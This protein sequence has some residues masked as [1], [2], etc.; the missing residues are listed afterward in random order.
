MDFLTTVSHTIT[1][2]GLLTPGE[3]CL[4]ALSGGADSVALLTA[5]IRLGFE[6]VAAHCNF[7]LRGAES[8][9]DEAFSRR[10]CAKL[11]VRLHVRRFDTAAE[12]RA[13]GESI[14]MAARRLRYAWFAELMA[15][16]GIGRTAVGHHRDDNVETLLLNLVRGTGIHGLTGMAYERD[17]IIRPLLDVSHADV[18]AFLVAE[19]Q[20]Y[21]TD[22]SNTDVRFK[23]NLVRHEL[24]PLLRQLNPSADDTLVADM[25]K[26]RAAEEAYDAVAATTF[27]AIAQ[28]TPWGVSFPLAALR[29]RANFDAIGRRFGF[30]EAT[31]RAIRHHDEGSGRALYTSPTHLA[32]ICRGRLDVCPRPADYAARPLPAKGETPL[33]DGRLLRAEWL[34]REALTDIPRCADAVALDADC[35]SGPAVVRRVTEGER[36]V[37]F[38]MRGSKLVSDLLTDRHVS[39]IARLFVAAVADDAGIL[40]LAGHRPAARAAITTQT[41]RVVRLTILQP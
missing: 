35:F 33:P 14:E 32:A 41:R 6:P 12:A 40:W 20:D 11:G 21:V 18:L 1:A 39:Q 27:D 37:P 38:G 19:G 17:A 7:G 4:V 3:R 34:P 26:L 8:D 5:L 31:M 16:C 10:L 29:Y 22:S 28:Q 2:H 30:S 36:F 13:H 24:L 9:R 23:R 15:D 25:R